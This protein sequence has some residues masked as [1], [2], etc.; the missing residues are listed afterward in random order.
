M[1]GSAPRQSSVDDLAPPRALT[2]KEKNLL[3]AKQGRLRNAAAAAG[4]TA[5]AQ[6]HQTADFSS[7]QRYAGDEQ[8]VTTKLPRRR[9]YDSI[10]Q[11]EVG[12]SSPKI[13]SSVRRLPP[14]LMSSVGSFPGGV[15]G[16]IGG[17]ENH[18]A[19]FSMQ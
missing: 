14:I 16:G 15:G 18:P 17:A 11:R 9:S 5:A 4:G 1:G 13:G 12:F 10:D 2:Q 8:P 7:A 3:H 19:D 6:E